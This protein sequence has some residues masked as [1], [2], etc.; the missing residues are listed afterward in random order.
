MMR[1]FGPSV[2]DRHLAFDLRKAVADQDD[3][4][5]SNNGIGMTDLIETGSADGR[6]RHLSRACEHPG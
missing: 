2:E 3:E 1:T 5:T 6:R 4:A